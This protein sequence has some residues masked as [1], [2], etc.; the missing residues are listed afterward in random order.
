MIFLSN[1]ITL[2]KYVLVNCF[3]FCYTHRLRMD[4][5][6]EQEQEDENE[7]MCSCSFCVFVQKYCQFWVYPLGFVLV[8][9]KLEKI[10]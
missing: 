7:S 4:L 3:G 6:Q 10:T 9:L 2:S 5:T 8:P 1:L